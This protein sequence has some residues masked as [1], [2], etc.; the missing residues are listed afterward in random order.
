MDTVFTMLT[1]F[2]TQCIYLITM[3]VL[4]SYKTIKN[5]VIDMV[6]ETVYIVCIGLLMYYNKASD[7]TKTVESVF[8]YLF[9]GSTF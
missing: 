3:I 5:N 2:I 4:R 1:L 8:I 6:N 7:W 9:L